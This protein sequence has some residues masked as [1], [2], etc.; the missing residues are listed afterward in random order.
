MAEKRRQFRKTGEHCLSPSA[1]LR[2]A[3]ASCAAPGVDEHRMGLEEPWQ[4]DNGFGSF[5]RNKRGSV[6]GHEILQ[7]RYMTEHDLVRRLP[8]GVAVSVKLVK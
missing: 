4:G 8:K 3:S 6:F 5:C 7:V 1:K 2:A